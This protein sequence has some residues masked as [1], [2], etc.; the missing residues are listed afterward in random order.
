MAT[1]KPDASRQHLRKPLHSLIKCAPKHCNNIRHSHT[2]LT[3]SLY[4]SNTWYWIFTVFCPFTFYWSFN[5]IQSQNKRRMFLFT[6]STLAW[7]KI[8]VQQ[9]V[10]FSPF[11]DS[12]KETSVNLQ[13]QSWINLPR[14][15]EI[16]GTFSKT[17][18]KSIKS[19]PFTDLYLR[20]C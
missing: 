6:F 17:S 1:L 16:R 2:T 4:Q 7:K 20:T 13:Q 15:P 3:V 14:Y 10:L 18:I 19:L 12:N 5:S 11:E 9:F 8:G